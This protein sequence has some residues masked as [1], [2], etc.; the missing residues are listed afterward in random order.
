MWI[1]VNLSSRTSSRERMIASSKLPPSQL[2]NA[3]QHVLAERQLA[4]VGRRAVGQRL[5]PCVTRSPLDHDRALVDAG[6]LVGADELPQR[7]A[8]LV[9]VVVA[10][11]DLRRASTLIDLAVAVGDDAPGRSRARPG[12]PCPCRPAALGAQQRHGLALHVRAHQGAVGVVVLQ[13]RDQR[14]ATRHDLLRR[15]VHVVDLLGAARS[16][17]CSPWRT[18][19]RVLD[20][21]AVC[22]EQ[23]V[24][25]GDDV[26]ALPRRRPGSGSRR[27]RTA[28]P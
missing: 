3:H 5:C 20:E 25:L 22:V 26:A 15:D 23:R 16:R 2:M 6:A 28:G 14:A 18:S 21:V 13:E 4:L 10:H 27:R 12:A 9:A 17:S 24:R 7:V 11:D 19:T 1:E 8:R